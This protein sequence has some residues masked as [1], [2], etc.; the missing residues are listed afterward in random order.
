MY[1]R[2]PD[3]T[4]QW[5]RVSLGVRG[6][7][8][9]FSFSSAGSLARFYLPVDTGSTSVSRFR[10][11]VSSRSFSLSLSLSLSW[12]S[13]APTESGTFS[14][15]WKSRCY[16]TPIRRGAPHD[17][18]TS[19]PGRDRT[20]SL[21]RPGPYWTAVSRVNPVSVDKRIYTLVASALSALISR[22]E[23][24]RHVRQR[25]VGF[26]HAENL[27]HVLYTFLPKRMIRYSV[28]KEQRK[29]IMTNGRSTEE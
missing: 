22:K 19:S 21:S 17:P 25:A 20:T 16:A 28:H 14:R 7:S 15:C 1:L 12:R 5:S 13:R 9:S 3:E 4:G 6:A 18:A 11:F 29:R 2:R 26:T 8:S 23:N 27:Y 24:R 10:S